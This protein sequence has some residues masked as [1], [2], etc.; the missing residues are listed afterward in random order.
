MLLSMIVAMGRQGQIGLDGDL[1][2]RAPSDLRH[3][4]RLTMGHHLLMGRKTFD[5]IGRPLPGRR[6]MV[7]SRQEHLALP[8]GV[9]VVPS[10]A[11]ACQLARSRGEDELFLAG[12][13]ALYREGLKLCQ[14]LYATFVDYD[15]PADCLFPLPPGDPGWERWK[16]VS[17]E[18]P[19]E[20]REGELGLV[21]RTLQSSYPTFAQ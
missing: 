21:F 18:E 1:P 15:G 11:S 8:E 19:A 10:V 20:R 12:G 3:F 16:L 13:A 7:L 9:E 6:I 4:R 5:S 17:E 14:R 2:W